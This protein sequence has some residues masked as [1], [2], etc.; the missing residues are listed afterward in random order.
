MTDIFISYSHAHKGF[1]KELVDRLND[2]GVSV[3]W[4]ANIEPTSADWR[5]DIDKAIDNTKLLVLVMSNAANDSAYVTF[6]WSYALGRNKQILMLMREPVEKIH[7]RLKHKQEFRFY[8][9]SVY[10]W[11]KLITLVKTI[12]QEETE[13]IA[14]VSPN[15]QHEALMYALSDLIA[16]GVI[17]RQNLGVFTQYGLLDPKEDY[18]KLKP[19]AT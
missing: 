11:E 3:W 16:G 8:D 9:S 7:P 6:E 19:D 18:P 10:P 4:D 1:V 12:L 15:T 17:R 14:S 13:K 2:E 5:I